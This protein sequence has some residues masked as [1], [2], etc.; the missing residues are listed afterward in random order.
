M[1]QSYFSGQF[2][3]SVHQIFPLSMDYLSNVI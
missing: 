2:S 3:D 1:L